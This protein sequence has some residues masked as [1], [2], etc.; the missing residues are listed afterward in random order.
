[1]QTEKFQRQGERIMP[2]MRFKIPTLGSTD[3]AGHSLTLEL[4]FLGLHRRSVI[5][6]IFYLAVICSS[7]T[8]RITLVHVARAGMSVAILMLY[9][10][11]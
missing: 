1:M 4:G 5:D 3:N 2:E 7:S 6:S 11:S 10:T 9:L 8:A